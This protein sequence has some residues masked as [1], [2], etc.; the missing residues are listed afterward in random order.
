MKAFVVI[1]ALILTPSVVSAHTKQDRQR[2]V[3]QCKQAAGQDRTHCKLKSKDSKTHA[4]CER[5]YR[6]NLRRC[7]E[8]R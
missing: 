7:G 1:L 8:Q 3:N 6:E 5:D 4:Q 2:Q